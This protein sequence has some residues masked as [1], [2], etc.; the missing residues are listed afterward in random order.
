MKRKW[1]HLNIIGTFWLKTGFENTHFKINTEHLVNNS[2]VHTIIGSKVW[3]IC[4]YR[5]IKTNHANLDINPAVKSVHFQSNLES[6]GCIIKSCALYTGSSWLHGGNLIS[7]IHCEYGVQVH[8]F[9]WC[10]LC[11]PMYSYQEFLLQLW[12][13]AGHKVD[14]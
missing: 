12:R 11:V 1:N 8:I 2:M 7:S 3:G 13:Y 6:T 14:I 10:T 4:F 5:K 9:L